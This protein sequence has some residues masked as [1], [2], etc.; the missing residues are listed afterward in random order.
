MC[1]LY[2]AGVMKMENELGCIKPG[3]IASLVVMNKKFEAAEL[4]AG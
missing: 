4:V 2:P 3:A 1:S